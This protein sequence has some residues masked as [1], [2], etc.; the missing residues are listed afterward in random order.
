MARSVLCVCSSTPCGRLVQEKS[1]AT[2]KKC[3]SVVRLLQKLRPIECDAHLK[4]LLTSCEKH[5]A[6][7]TMYLREPGR[8]FEPRLSAHW[9][10]SASV[11]GRIAVA[12]GR[13]ASSCAVAARLDGVTAIGESEG[14]TCVGGH[15]TGHDEERAVE[16]VSARVADY[17]TRILVSPCQRRSRGSR[18]IGPSERRHQR[19]DR[20]WEGSCMASRG[21]SGY[22]ATGYPQ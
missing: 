22:G 21:V 20:G 7:A 10:A 12:A 1:A 4:I 9:L 3:A 13:D 11:L 18:Q 19:R 6:L 16:G 2:S 17:S 5:P 8:A 14:S 15:P